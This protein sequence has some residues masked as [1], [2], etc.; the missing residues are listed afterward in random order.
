VRPVKQGVA[1]EAA[2]D[3]HRDV[4]EACGS[5]E[6]GRL[7]HAPGQPRRIVR[8]SYDPVSET[9]ARQAPV[10]L[11]ELTT[12]IERYESL[13]LADLQRMREECE[14][15]FRSWARD[16]ANAA[17]PLSEA[18]DY[19]DRIALDSLLERRMFVE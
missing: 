1:N 12:V 17:R 18:P 7:G 2:D 13:A 15:R 8:V 5:R 4:E 10:A 3:T 14:E 9:L 16:P 6:R 11:P 19:L